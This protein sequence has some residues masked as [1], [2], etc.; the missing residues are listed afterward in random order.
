MKR[1]VGLLMLLVGCGA[2]RMRPVD[3]VR[4]VSVA[5]RDYA[6]EA[7]KNMRFLSL[8]TVPDEEKPL[9]AGIASFVLNSLG[10]SGYIARPQWVP[11]TSLIAFNLRDYTASEETYKTHWE[12]WEKLAGAEPYFHVQQDIAEEIKTKDDKGKAVV[13]T[14]VRTVTVDAPWLPEALCKEV[15]EASASIGPVMRLEHWLSQVMVPPTYYT[16]AGVPETEVAFLELL[17]IDAADV[18]ARNRDRGANVISKVALGHTR[19]ISSYAGPWGALFVTKDSF[20]T[21]GKNDAIRQPLNR[22]LNPTTNEV[23]KLFEFDAGEFIAAKAN[24]LH[25]FALYNA[26][27]AR[28]D[29]VPLGGPGKSIARDT[30]EDHPNF[31]AVIVPGLSCVRC[32]RESGLRPIEDMQSTLPGLAALPD[33][34]ALLSFYNQPQLQL[35]LKQ[36]REQYALAVAQACDLSSEQVAEGL[37]NLV[38]VHLYDLVTAER[39]AQE[40]GAELGAFLETAKQVSD[41]YAILLWQGRAVHRE[42]WTGSFPSVMTA[43]SNGDAGAAQ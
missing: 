42:A 16:L 40:C 11:G 31:D 43:L 15:R 26:A 27:G 23:V 18:R 35:R 12:T 2:D 34:Q 13:D 3:E 17:G 25:L 8:A 30:S 36:A 14:K 7:A 5:L 37:G 29:A 4:Q 33:A 38:R 41:P 19:R 10:D 9:A 20:K 39:A 22:S 28:Q 32:H 21:F 6:P 1:L 24:G